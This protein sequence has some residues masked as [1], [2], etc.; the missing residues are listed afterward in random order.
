VLGW[1]LVWDQDQETAIRSPHGG[2]KITWGGPPLMPKT[3]K[4][5]VH[6]DL[7]PTADSDDET[8]VGRLVSLGASRLD[9]DNG[10][11]G[12]VWMSDPDGREFRVLTP[13]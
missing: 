12:W 2:P 8:E 6:F 3:G 10:E 11:L 7:A 13:R 9:V 5:R 4:D 1:P